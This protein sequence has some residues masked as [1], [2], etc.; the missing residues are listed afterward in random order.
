MAK[1]FICETSVWDDPEFPKIDKVIEVN[2][3]VVNKNLI[4]DIVSCSVG[5]VK[6]VSESHA[7]VLF[8]GKKKMYDLDRRG[9]VVVDIFKTGKEEGTTTPPFKYKICNIC[10]VIKNQKEEFEYNQNDKQGRP[11][12]RP[13]C[14]TCRVNINGK[15]MPKSER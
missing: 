7:S 13:S 8:I 3:F 6:A 11:T 9:L 4:D 2:D 10:H 14:R 12:T 1:S 15:T 5:V